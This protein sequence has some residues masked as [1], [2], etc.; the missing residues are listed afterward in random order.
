M[1]TS[2]ML[3]ATFNFMLKKNSLSVCIAASVIA[4]LSIGL[5]IGYPRN[6]TQ[7]SQYFNANRSIL[8]NNGNGGLLNN[9]DGKSFFNISKLYKTDKVTSHNYGLYYEKYL[10]KY[11]GSS[12]DLLEI[13]LGC[14]MPYG[15]GASAHVW[16]SYLGPLANIHFVEFD[17]SCGEAWYTIDGYKV[18]NC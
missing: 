11:V 12:V 5:W 17:R 8:L 15:P 16:R 2:S 14:G 9:T 4:M 18:N 10:R 7:I 3:P 13:G 1:A 6:L